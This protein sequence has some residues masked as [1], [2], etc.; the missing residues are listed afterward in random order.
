MQEQRVDTTDQSILNGKLFVGQVPKDMME[1]NLRPYFDSFGS[2]REITIIRD[3]LS[4]L[5]RGCAFVIYHERTAAQNAMDALH[6]IL[7]LP[8]ATNPLQVRFAETPLDRETKLFIGMLP[9]SFSKNE[10]ATMFGAFGEIKEIHIIRGPEGN[11]QGCAFVK[12]V[13]KEAAAAAIQALNDTIPNGATR[14][15]VVRYAESKGGA[16]SGSD[17]G[18][19]K[20]MGNAGHDGFHGAPVGYG[21]SQST[22]LSQQHQHLRP[23]AYLQ[24]QQQPHSSHAHHQA[25]QQQQPRSG[26]HQMGGYLSGNVSNG[27]P[28][29]QQ[30]P[31]TQAMQAPSHLRPPE[32]PTGANLFVYHL[33]RDISDAD[34]ATLFAPFGNVISAK[35]FVDPKTSDSKGFGFVSYDRQDSANN[36]ISSM[37][38]FQIGSKRLKVEHKRISSALWPTPGTSGSTGMSTAHHVMSHHQ[39]GNAFVDPNDELTAL[40]SAQMQIAPAHHHAQT[41][42][43]HL[44]LQPAPHHSNAGGM[45]AGNSNNNSNLNSTARMRGGNE[46]TSLYT[47]SPPQQH[48]HHNMPLPQQQQQQLPLVHLPPPQQQ[49]TPPPAM[50][51]AAFQQQQQQLLSLQMQQ[52]QQSSSNNGMNVANAMHQQQQQPYHPGLVMQHLRPPNDRF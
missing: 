40:Y 43:R 14:P 21:G 3:P 23:P 4:G 26:G 52:Q 6:N 45:M 17:S 39:Q 34:L 31:Q 22:L 15:M 10:V 49:Q 33:P 48:F 28:I 27:N 44:P 42:S 7:H 13:D 25:H 32:G 16:A 47:A 9:K 41:A 20:N 1:D 2:I 50:D 35:V 12:F 8:N 24:Q 37:N 19:G 29:Q 36:A 51:Y 30:S 46:M 11:P 5:S 38:G 18:K